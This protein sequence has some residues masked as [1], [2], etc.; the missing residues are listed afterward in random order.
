M[1]TEREPP[2][3]AYDRA[4]ASRILARFGA[5]EPFGRVGDAVSEQFLG[6]ARRVDPQ[7]TPLVAASGSHLTSSQLDYLSSRM[8]LCRSESVTSA[9]HTVVWHDSDGVVN[10]THCG[11]SALGAVVPVVARETTLA[12]WRAL[13]A[14]EDARPAPLSAGDQVTMAATTT[15]REPPETF[16]V[17]IDT[18]SRALVQHAYLAGQTPYR[19]PAE[20]ARGLRDSAIF[21]LGLDS[22]ERRRSSEYLALGIAVL[23][24][25]TAA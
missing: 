22:T 23:D 11:P 13:A 15:D 18:I 5:A 10:V 7:L 8:R 20:F 3:A 1:S 14:N 21:L 25:F 9:T 4:A 6:G 2:V 16:R 24:L 19:G 17:G 12:M